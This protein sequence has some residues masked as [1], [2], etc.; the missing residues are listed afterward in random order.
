MS[1]R[2]Y[3]IASA[4]PPLFS[5]NNPKAHMLFCLR[6]FLPSAEQHY[7]GT[8][9]E[10]SSWMQVH[11]RSSAHAHQFSPNC[12]YN[13]NTPQ[14]CKYYCLLTPAW[15]LTSETALGYIFPCLPTHPP[16]HQPTDPSHPLPRPSRTNNCCRSSWTTRTSEWETSAFETPRSR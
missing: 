5:H 15:S 6:S 2:R 7:N 9:I 12:K 1:T 3:H 16:T 8:T 10:W 14:V 11:C 4:A 13:N